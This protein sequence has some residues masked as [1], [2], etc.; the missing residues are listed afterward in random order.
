VPVL[1]ERLA[2]SR[3]EELET[4]LDELVAIARDRWEGAAP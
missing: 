2:R 4:G 3:K 1:E